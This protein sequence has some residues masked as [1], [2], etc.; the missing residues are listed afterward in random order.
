MFEAII[1]G[2]SP[3]DAPKIIFT[4][5]VGS[6]HDGD[7]FKCLRTDT[8]RNELP[9]V[10]LGFG[11]KIVNRVFSE[12]YVEEWACRMRRINAAELK[13]PNVELALQAEAELKTLLTGVTLTVHLFG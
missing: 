2:K 4:T 8:I 5:A 11:R 13:G 1:A 10:D 6:V 3:N 9:P 7:T 12:D